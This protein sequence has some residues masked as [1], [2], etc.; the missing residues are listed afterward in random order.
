MKYKIV[1]EFP[2]AIMEKGK[3]PVISIYIDT[4]IKKPDRLENHIYFKNLV[5]EAQESIKHK[6]VRGF[7]D[8]FSLFKIMEDDALFWEGATEGMAILA[9][10][11]ECIVYKLPISVTNRAIVADSFYIKPILKSYQLN[12]RYHVLALKGDS[13][14]L[15]E[16][17]R[18]R[19]HQ[20]HL[21]EKH[22]TI[23]GVLGDEKTVPHK[24]VGTPTGQVLH[25]HGSAKD[26]KKVDQLK[27]FRYADAFI[28]E[29]YSNRY[30]VP[31]ILVGLDEN[32]GEFRKLSKNQYL[33]KEGI[34]GD[35]DSMDEK[36]LYDKVQG[37]MEG[38]FKQQLKEWMEAFTEAH[39]KD[40]GS[41][42]V[43]QI[44]RAITDN[45]VAALYLEEDKFHP[46]RFDISHGSIV[47]GKSEDQYSGDIYDDM[48]EAVL[49]RGGEV[50]ILE[51]G[52]M[53]TDRDI[54]AVY[55]F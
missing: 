19:I 37:V 42:D 40:L 53:P 29:Q 16:A 45:R 48:A 52:E 14:A 35:V 25:G 1:E 11:E 54:A 47:E 28:Q 8:L 5:R 49:S 21:D 3:S 33:I 12:G 4:K 2:H 15:Y 51:K 30:K 34:I 36:T 41:D 17:N 9:D 13:Y 18:H 7:R 20:I 38:I 44:A 23:D 46:G 43:V 50:V 55:R 24:S 10:D 39:A 22:S 6:E 32:Q 27:F 26:E 31:L